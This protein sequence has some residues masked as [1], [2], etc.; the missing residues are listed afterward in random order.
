[1]I[2][3]SG[4]SAL[5]M[6]EALESR[7]HFAGYGYDTTFGH[8]GAVRVEGV[9]WNSVIKSMRA[10]ARTLVSATI[11]DG[12]NSSV[13]RLLALTDDGKIDRSFA[14]LGVLRTKL[15]PQYVDHDTGSIVLFRDPDDY[16]PSGDVQIVDKYGRPMTS[17]GPEGRRSLTVRGK[18]FSP[19][20]VTR[21]PDGDWLFAG[22][23]ED[24]VTTENDWGGTTEWQWGALRLRA[25]GTPR[26][27]VG[28]NG[29]VRVDAE[30]Y[31]YTS[32]YSPEDFDYAFTT[33]HD[34]ITGVGFVVTGDFLFL[35]VKRD[36]YY[37][38]SSYGETTASASIVLHR[39]LPE[40]HLDPRWNGNAD[41]TELATNARV[42][43]PVLE[44]GRILVPVLGAGWNGKPEPRIAVYTFDHRGHRIGAIT[45]DE[46]TSSG[47]TVARV[48]GGWLVINR[49]TNGS[50]ATRFR[51]DLA[52]DTGWGVLGNSVAPSDADAY[53]VDREG[54]VL[55][56]G[57]SVDAERGAPVDLYRLDG[58]TFDRAAPAYLQDRTL[59]VLGTDAADTL[60]LHYRS[61]F[62][63]VQRNDEPAQ[64]FNA[65]SFDNISVLGGAGND[66]I[67][68][69]R[70]I[71]HLAIY[72]E[73]G[74]D[75]IFGSD[76]DDTID[77]GVGDDRINGRGGADSLLGGDGADHIDGGT[78]ADTLAGGR[79]NDKLSGQSGDD[80]LYGNDGRDS[81]H[82][83]ANDDY[84]H[85]NTGVD[86]LFGADGD[87]HLSGGGDP[88]NLLDG[89]AGR[90]LYER[91]DDSYNDTQIDIED[92]DWWL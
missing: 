30:S 27:S 72:G 71:P 5:R 19:D 51:D 52:V 29:F 83:G 77:G 73:S 4:A 74:G 69:E 28:E 81:L 92:G 31:H 23:V 18:V 60:H 35:G 1:M 22:R 26:T 79:G 34:T 17:F 53:S 36:D 88:G 8:D 38:S 63:G 45:S 59:W 64:R 85:G 41:S 40:G 44:R 10:G 91:G 55:V 46:S 66:M 68:V 61:G 11:A 54:R 37:Y 6:I 47:D 3:L 7:R 86:R 90:D 65:R 50:G 76:L 14:R 42:Q 67:D 82:G 87:D 9:Q 12:P 21:L 56:W 89:G 15:A 33:D 13:T 57:D 25:D 58:S 2:D 80:H 75:T 24:P 78:G 70:R 48:R 32:Y 84:L 62:V 39:F 43:T 20:T 49:L 16:A